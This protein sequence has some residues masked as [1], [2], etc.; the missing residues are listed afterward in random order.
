MCKSAWHI[1]KTQFTSSLSLSLFP[2]HS[3]P[4]I[5]FMEGE[6]C[7]ILIGQPFEFCHMEWDPVPR[8]VYFVYTMWKRPGMKSH[9]PYNWNWTGYYVSIVIVVQWKMKYHQLA[10]TACTHK[11]NSYCLWKM[12]S[13][14]KYGINKKLVW[15]RYVCQYLCR[16]LQLIAQEGRILCINTRRICIVVDACFPRQ[17]AK[18]NHPITILLLFKVSNNNVG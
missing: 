9:D 7:S 6:I 2:L 8:P 17:V 12:W 11:C 18:A 14:C 1:Q 3:S 16:Y 15:C 5:E 4:Q 10:Y 13:P